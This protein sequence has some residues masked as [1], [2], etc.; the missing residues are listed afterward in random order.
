[1]E[2]EYKD[3]CDDKRDKKVKSN[4][5][6]KKKKQYTNSA[7]SNSPDYFIRPKR[8]IRLLRKNDI[9]EDFRINDKYINKVGKNID[10]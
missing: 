3:L 1:M 8:V 7:R 5:Y 9:R 10:R 4:I 2:K 6:I